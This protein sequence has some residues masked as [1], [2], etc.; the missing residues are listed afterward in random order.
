[1]ASN[2][3]ILMLSSYLQADPAMPWDP[4][5]PSHLEASGKVFTVR[6]VPGDK[7]A[8]LYVLGKNAA[9]IEVSKLRVEARLQTPSGEKIIEFQPQKGYFQTQQPIIGDHLDLKMKSHDGTSENLRLK[10]RRP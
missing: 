6:L 9:S 1:M 8:V 5:H 4:T 10:L 3:L 7:K 2:L